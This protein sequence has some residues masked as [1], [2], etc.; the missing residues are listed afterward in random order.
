[1]REFLQ[2]ARSP[3]VQCVEEDFVAGFEHQS[4]SSSSVVIP[5]HVILCFVDHRFGFVDCCLHP[6]RELV[7]RLL[8]GVVLLGFK[9]HARNTPS[10]K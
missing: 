6:L 2:R 4:W 5:L 10:V 8:V 1:M 9:A 7:D 3:D